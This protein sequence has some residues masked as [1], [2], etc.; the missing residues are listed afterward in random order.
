MPLPR[1]AEGEVVVTTPRAARRRRELRMVAVFVVAA[2]PVA[3]VVWL[4]VN[5]PAAV[6]YVVAQTLFLWFGF[7]RRADP[8][9][10]LSPTGISYEPGR[11]QVRCEWADVDSIGTVT[12]PDAGEVEALILSV[13]ALHWAADEPVRREAIA[14]GWDRAVPIGSFEPEWEWGRIGDAVRTWAPWI[15]DLPDA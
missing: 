10:R 2:L 15:F 9:L 8:L 14:R 3:A 12:L 13:S 1:P 11:F 7:R 6:L 4:I 5:A